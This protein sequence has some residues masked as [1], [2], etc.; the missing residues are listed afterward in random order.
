VESIP[1][2]HIDHVFKEK[3]GEMFA[4]ANF[5]VPEHCAAIN[6]FNLFY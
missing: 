2:G 6:L 4:R 3:L 5:F 1:K